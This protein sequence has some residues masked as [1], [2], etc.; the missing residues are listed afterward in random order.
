MENTKLMKSA[1]IID[2][3][4]KVLQGFAL[5][6]VIVPAIFIPLTAIFGEKVIASSSRLDLGAVDLN[7]AGDTLAYMDL[8]HIKVSI[9]VM[10]LGGIVGAAAIWYCLRVLR[11]ILS[12]MKDGTPFASGIAAQVRKLG[13]TVLIGGVVAEIGRAVAH[14]FEIRAYHLEQLLDPNAVSSISY[15]YSVS[16]WFVVTALILFFLSYVFRYGEE[17]QREADETL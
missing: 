4:L 11:Q 15:N 14:L 16:L 8:P 3:I 12:P 10:L 6:G 5:A 9:I 13:W 2:R 7:L 1:S 17:L